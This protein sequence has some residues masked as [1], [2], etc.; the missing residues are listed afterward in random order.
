MSDIEDV[1]RR[2]VGCGLKIHQELGPGMLESVYEAVL[3][4]SMTRL[5][6]K[7]ERQRPIEIEYDGMI[8]REGFRADLVID[9]SLI[10]ELKV[11]ERLAPVHGKQLLTYLK[12][13]KMR[14]GLLMNFGT[15]TFR[16]GLKRIVN[17]HV[18][19]D[20]SSLRINRCR[21]DP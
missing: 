20:S 14:L 4:A 13:A 16:E 5:G 12:L 11:A 10:I 21:I 3:A 9:G 18:A 2:A 7:V 19:T 1:C 17:N 15:P 6:H 8:L